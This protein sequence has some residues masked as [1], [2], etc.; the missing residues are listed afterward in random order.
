MLRE[1]SH[2]VR[3]ETP[4]GPGTV[5]PHPFGVPPEGRRGGCGDLGRL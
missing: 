3:A 2:S 1:R 4:R 5:W